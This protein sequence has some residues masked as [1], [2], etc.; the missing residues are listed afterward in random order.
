MNRKKIIKLMLVFSCFVAI[1]FNYP[2]AVNAENDFETNKR[3]YIS[4]C[5]SSTLTRSEIAT[6]EEFNIYLQEESSNL[7]SK[8]E[9][10]NSS[11]ATTK[12]QIDAVYESINQLEGEI[13][14]KQE[15]IDYVS[16]QIT[17]QEESIAKIEKTLKD[18]LYEMQ[19]Y[20]NSNQM[21]DFI[22]GASSFGDLIS[23]IESVNDLT[24]YDKDL[25]VKLN[26]EK[27]KL[28][29]TKNWAEQEKSTL[30]SLQ[31]K[32]FAKQNELNQ[33]I[34]TYTA[35]IESGQQALAEN[36]EISEAL[37]NAVGASRLTLEQQEWINNNGAITDNN[38]NLSGTVSDVVAYAVSKIG[39]PYVWGAAG[40]NSFDCSGLTSWAYAQVGV[41][42]GRTTYNQAPN[43][44]AVA[45]SN[46]QPG[47]LLFFNTDGYLSHVGMYVGNGLMV[48]APYPGATVT[49]TNVNI[50]YWQ[51]TYNCARR[52][53]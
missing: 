32:Q 9:D 30:I 39:S 23:R 19:S 31:V 40:P 6:C 17:M 35:Q 20:V 53:I 10:L 38:V 36:E 12:E 29:E 41:N 18:R 14:E 4:L 26:N 5:Q 42:I 24:E 16:L 2:S 28:E 21:F 48:H 3:H 44:T 7:E 15:M 22:L 8:I 46:I 13:N 11:L 47:D 52:Y 37:R 43:G 25:V 51:S 45:Y 1:A 49:Y 33:L 27:V 50:A 34:E